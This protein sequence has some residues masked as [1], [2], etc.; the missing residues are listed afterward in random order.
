MFSYEVSLKSLDGLFTMK[1]FDTELEAQL[2]AE[3]AYQIHS[4][5]GHDIEIQVAEMFRHRNGQISY[6][7]LT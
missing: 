2:E 7:M 5:Y 4:L 6:T 1:Y 3:L